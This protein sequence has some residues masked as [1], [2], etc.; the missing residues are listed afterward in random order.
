[1]SAGSSWP[2]LARYLG[3]RAR[4]DLARAPAGRRR[5]RTASRLHLKGIGLRSARRLLAAPR[6]LLRQAGRFYPAWRG[7]RGQSGHARRA[8][9][10]SLTDDHPLVAGS[11]PASADQL[12]LVRSAAGFEIPARPSCRSSTEESE[13]GEAASP[14]SGAASAS[15]DGAGSASLDDLVRPHLPRALRGQGSADSAASR[16]TRLPAGPRSARGRADPATLARETVHHLGRAANGPGAGY[17]HQAG[18]EPR[19]AGASAELLRCWRLPPGPRRAT[20]RSRGGGRAR[21]RMLRA[22]RRR[23]S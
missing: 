18:R 3:T 17:P 11:R 8:H 13:R 7:Q 15:S 4:S 19:R 1:V 21:L 9:A 10:G 20:R 14:R 6:R 16:A 12:T 2:E 5:I 22:A 23:P